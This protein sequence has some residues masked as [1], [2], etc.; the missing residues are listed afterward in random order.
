MPAGHGRYEQGLDERR[1]VLVRAQDYAAIIAAALPGS[2]EAQ[3]LTE[4]AAGLDAAIAGNPDQID[5]ALAAYRL[6]FA[7]LRDDL[8][9]AILANVPIAALKDAVRQSS[10]S[11][12]Q[13][14][15]SGP[16]LVG[17]T[18]PSATLADPRS[19]SLIAVGPMPTKA[20]QTTLA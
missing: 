5:A 9:D 14:P 17:F 13:R 3:A 1:S 20:F 10:T 18:T 2:P 6:A 12:M 7:A 16:L 11:C 8:I 15:V 19:G 4:A